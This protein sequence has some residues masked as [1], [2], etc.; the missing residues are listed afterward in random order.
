MT[1]DELYEAARQ[2]ADELFS[3]TSVS[4]AETRAN[5]NTLI[6]DISLMLAGLPDDEDEE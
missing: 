3:D 1:N 6:E 2:A 5:M 4:V